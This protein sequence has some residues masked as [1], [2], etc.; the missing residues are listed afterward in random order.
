M[1]MSAI[2]PAISFCDEEEWCGFIIE[3][4]QMGWFVSIACRV[5]R[6]TL[7]TRPI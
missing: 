3:V 4:R 5:G 6:T 2:I 7:Q 1:D